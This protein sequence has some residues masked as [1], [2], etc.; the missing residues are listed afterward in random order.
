[1]SVIGDLDNTESAARGL[2]LRNLQKRQVRYPV[3]LQAREVRELVVVHQ[4]GPMEQFNLMDV[5]RRPLSP[6]A[7]IEV[8]AS[9]DE[10]E[11]AQ[12]LLDTDGNK[13]P[14][15]CYD[16]TRQIA[17]VVAAPTPLHGDMVGELC[18]YPRRVSQ[19]TDITKHRRAGRGLTIREWDGGLRYMVNDDEEKK[20]M[21][22]FEVGVSQSYRSLQEAISWCVCAL[23]CRLAIAMCLDEGPRGAKSDGQYYANEE[24][25]AAAI[26]QATNELRL[27][28]RQ[29]PFGPLVRNGVTWFGTLEKVVIETFRCENANCPPGTLLCPTRSF[30][31]GSTSNVMQVVIRDGQSGAEDIPPNLGEVVLGDCVPSHVLSGDEILAT[32][33]DFFQKSWIEA[34]IRSAILETAVERI[35]NKCFIL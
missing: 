16:S 2:A 34:K 1:M 15:L 33:I 26:L 9:W 5:V 32:P 35:E 19:T 8:P 10:Y 31:E 27:Q 6:D 4:R 7:K 17:I 25:A 24:E 22:A 13:F 30:T 29:N 20:L 12:E 14:R 23:H 18:R 11:Y 28:L 3:S 21:V